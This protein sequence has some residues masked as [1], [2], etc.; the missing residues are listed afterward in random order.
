VSAQFPKT[1]WSLVARAGAPLTPEG[2]E[3]LSALCGRYWYPVYAF[4]RRRG[5]PAADAEDL[6]QGFFARLFE[7]NAI[8]AADPGRGRFRSW[9]L[10]CLKHYVA[11]AHDRAR[12]EKRGGGVTVLSF[13]AEEAQR[14]Y[15]AE[16]AHHLTPER[17]YERRFAL[18]LLDGVLD[19]LRAQYARRGQEPLFDALRGRISG[20]AEERGHE[21]VAAALGMNVAAV[22]TAASR[23]AERYREL[24][25]AEVAHLC[26][27]EGEVDDELGHL[28]SALGDGPSV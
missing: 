20:A 28:L 16:R 12:A 27:D 2:L 5:A 18:A 14:R 15:V 8:A 13:D 23:L 10:G 21:E 7:T 3:A 25:R 26:A 9:L 6:T 22:R 19:D 11:N 1:S 24:L 17:L 4:V